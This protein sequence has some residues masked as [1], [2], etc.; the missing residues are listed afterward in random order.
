MRKVV[1]LPVFGTDA[2]IDV[3]SQSL[4]FLIARSF[5]AF[6]LLFFIAVKA[7][8][9][10]FDATVHLDIESWDSMSVR[11]PASQGSTRAWIK[12][13]K[14]DAERALRASPWSKSG[15]ISVVTEKRF[16]LHANMTYEQELDAI[17]EWLKN[18]GFQDITIIMARCSIPP[19]G[20]W[21][22]I[23]RIWSWGQR[24]DP[25]MRQTVQGQTVQELKF[26]EQR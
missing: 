14:V 22:P 11:F 3:M 15:T 9:V 17:E 12:M 25:K 1:P 20:L 13:N 7:Q 2:W 6:F 21:P 26:E 8:D 16:D 24:L 10:V 5:L 23:Q 18:I 19:D 4:L